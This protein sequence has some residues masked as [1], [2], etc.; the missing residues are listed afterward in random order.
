MGR[1]HDE[2]K[3]E[4]QRNGEKETIRQWR[5]YKEWEEEM[6]RLRRS[7]KRMGRKDYQIVAKMQKRKTTEDTSERNICGRLVRGSNLTLEK[8]DIVMKVKY[9]GSS[10]QR[11]TPPTTS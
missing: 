11:K 4:V 3:E 10:Q 6:M 1:R 5:K 9:P 7:Y 8:G 2:T